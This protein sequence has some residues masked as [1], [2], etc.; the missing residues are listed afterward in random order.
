MD[1]RKKNIIIFGLEEKGDESYF[2]TLRVVLEF[3]R[4]P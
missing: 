2:D 3:L 4:V 1:I